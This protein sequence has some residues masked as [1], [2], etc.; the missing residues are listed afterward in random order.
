MKKR[1]MSLFLVISMSFTF[2]YPELALNDN[3]LE[4]I[5][6]TPEGEVYIKEFH[7]GIKELLQ[8][9]KSERKYKLKLLEWFDE[10]CR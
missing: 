8:M 9:P 6:E 4:C 10:I 3:V 1:A 7:I 5:E 2:F